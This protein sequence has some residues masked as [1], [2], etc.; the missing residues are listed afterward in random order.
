MYTCYISAVKYKIGRENIRTVYLYVTI[1]VQCIHIQHR[2]N[3]KMPMPLTINKMY[4]SLFS[5]Q[6][7]PC[8][9]DNNGITAYIQT[10]S[11]P[12]FLLQPSLFCTISSPPPPR[13]AHTH[14][15]TQCRPTPTPQHIYSS[16]LYILH[17]SI[18]IFQLNCFKGISFKPVYS[19][20]YSNKK[21]R[22]SPFSSTIYIR[23]TSL[24]QLY[25]RTALCCPFSCQYKVFP[26]EQVFHC[27]IITSQ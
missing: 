5:I 15:H 21:T 4:M 23:Q 20:I 2:L 26:S 14:T 3:L 18:K 11:S 24:L 22:L 8:D 19:F 12:W 10:V 16:P 27:A 9:T 17:H 25:V 6:N 7:V 13:S 1:P